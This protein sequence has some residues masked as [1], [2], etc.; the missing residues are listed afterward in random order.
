M[1]KFKIQGK[2]PNSTKALSVSLIFVSRNYLHT[3]LDR[4]LKS[5]SIF[6][7]NPDDCI[8][9]RA[10]VDEAIVTVLYPQEM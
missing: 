3:F 5:L 1:V 10:Q 8:C 4:Q 7:L 9:G 6:H 2:I